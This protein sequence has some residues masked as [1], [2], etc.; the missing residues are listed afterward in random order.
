MRTTAVNWFFSV[1]FRIHTDNIK[2]KKSDL[3]KFNYPSKSGKERIMKKWKGLRTCFTC[4]CPGV[5][6]KVVWPWELSLTGFALEWLNAYTHTGT[7]KCGHTHTHTAHTQGEDEYRLQY[8]GHAKMCQSEKNALILS[9]CAIHR[10]T[11][12]LNDWRNH[13]S[14]FTHLVRE[15]K[16]KHLGDFKFLFQIW[17][18]SIILLAHCGDGDC[19]KSESSLW[20]PFKK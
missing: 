12:V 2:L 11:L 18:I 13:K 4:M 9:M 19:G 5:G 1:L 7:H 14:V 17:R 15:W 20:G 10:Q 16:C 3:W 8:R 6:L